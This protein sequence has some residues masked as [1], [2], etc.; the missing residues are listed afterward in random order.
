MKIVIISNLYTPFSRGGAERVAELMAQGLAERGNDVCVITSAPRGFAPRFQSE[1]DKLKIYR[2]FPW[3]L[4]FYGNIGQKNWFLRFFWHILDVFNL[5]S[6]FVVKNI[7]S[8]EKPDI[9]FTHNLKGLGYLIPILLRKSHIPWLHTL[10]DVQL[11]TPSG[12]IIKGKEGSFEH[13]NFLTKFYRFICR[14]LFGSPAVVISPSRWLLDFYEKYN[15]FPKS[16]KVVLRNPIHSFENSATLSKNKDAVFTFL[17]TGQVEEHKGVVFLVNAFKQL[18]S[19]PQFSDCRLVIAGRGLALG[20]IK[21]LASE[22]PS[23]DVCG[24]LSARELQKEFGHADIL[25]APSLCYENSPMV[26]YEALGFGLPVLA[27]K[28]GGVAELIK[29]KKNGFIFE[30]GYREDLIEKMAYCLKHLDE[31]KTM[32]Q[33]A[34]ESVK[35]FSL[36]KY[37]EKIEKF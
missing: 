18:V 16:Q 27:A 8:A 10:H 34:R 1:N 26:I 2:F 15:F 23:I 28:I 25:V 9:V 31:I 20:I 17:Y 22:C 4:F 19:E 21:K 35:E 36:E 32:A 6:Y 24:W 14:K 13:T 12:L 5:H 7:L 30:A 33:A 29:D 37:I 11:I 3:N